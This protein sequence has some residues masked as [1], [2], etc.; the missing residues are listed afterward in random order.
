MNNITKLYNPDWNHH[1]KMIDY[2]WYI[3]IEYVSGCN[4][5]NIE[6]NKI[7]LFNTIKKLTSKQNIMRKH[8]LMK[9]FTYICYNDIQP[10]YSFVN[11]DSVYI[12]QS[13]VLTILKHKESIPKSLSTCQQKK[14]ISFLYKSTDAEE[15]TMIK[16]M[17]DSLI[18]E[19]VLHRCLYIKKII[20]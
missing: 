14:I 7:P 2:I 20:S 5:L 1:T 11:K 18:I 19:K 8:N 4:L 3:I 16:Y 12:K 15:K 10:L 17:Y 6:K 9:I 13:N